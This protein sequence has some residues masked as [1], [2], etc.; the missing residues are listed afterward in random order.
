MPLI[1]AAEQEFDV[2]KRRT[3]LQDLAAIHADNAPILFIAEMR[4]FIGV[5]ANLKNFKNVNRVFSY[6]AMTVE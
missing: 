6:D 1:E 5:A 3:M 2:D 4:D